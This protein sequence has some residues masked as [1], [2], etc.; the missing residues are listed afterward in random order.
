M[1]GQH[2]DGTGGMGQDK[3]PGQPYQPP[4]QTPQ[5]DS[6]TPSGSGDHRKD[7]KDGK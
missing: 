7:D 3:L 6:D 5:P 2:G 4:T 1:S